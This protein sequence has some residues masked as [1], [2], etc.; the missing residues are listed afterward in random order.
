MKSLDALGGVSDTR[1]KGREGDGDAPVLEGQVEERA[2]RLADVD[3]RGHLPFF[4]QEKDAGE[5]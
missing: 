5:P 1:K 4:H 2:R 3:S